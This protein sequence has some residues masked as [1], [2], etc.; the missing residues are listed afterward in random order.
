M[1]CDFCQDEALKQCKR[2]GKYACAA[3]LRALSQ[4][5][6][7]C[8]ECAAKVMECLQNGHLWGEWDRSPT[9]PCTKSRAC[10]R[11][12][13]IETSAEHEWVSVRCRDE[14]VCLCFV[15]KHCGEQLRIGHR[16]KVAGPRSEAYVCQI[17]G[18][19]R[20]RVEVARY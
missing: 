13:E 12:G 10:S 20:R 17:C 7:Y 14:E 5:E 4:D 8:I 15:C 18:Y 16:F 3:H 6:L 2:C 19:V 11:C 1:Q 9:E